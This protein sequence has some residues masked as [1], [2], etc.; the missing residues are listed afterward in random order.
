MEPSLSPSESR[1]LLAIYLRDHY[2][3][4]SAGLAL[5]RRCREANRG[6]EYERVLSD[7]EQEIA[8]DRLSLI[9]VMDRLDITPSKLK[10]AL[11]RLAEFV[12]RIKSNGH[13]TRYSPSSRVVELEGLAAGV[14]TKRNLWR[15]LSSVSD[16]ETT[17]PRRELTTLGDRATAQLDVILAAHER[18]AAEAFGGRAG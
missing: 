11:G 16:I 17:I 15:A 3:G 7:I 5:V 4:A 14:T 2:G 9:S 10:A 12:G 6:N 1:R 8:E 13:L 18:A